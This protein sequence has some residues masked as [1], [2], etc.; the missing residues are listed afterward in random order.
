M[1]YWAY[2]VLVT[3]I[4]HVNFVFPT[5]TTKMQK[6]FVYLSLYPTVTPASGTFSQLMAK[7][8]IRSAD[9]ETRI[10]QNLS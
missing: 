3:E 5:M 7:P 1:R 4:S 10:M 9:K 8:D 2:R 6:S